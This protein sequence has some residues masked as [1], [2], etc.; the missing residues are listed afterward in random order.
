MKCNAQAIDNITESYALS[1]LHDALK[2]IR[3][4]TPKKSF[5]LKKAASSDIRIGYLNKRPVK[6]LVVTLRSSGCGWIKN[7]F[8]CTMCGHYAGTTKGEAI[9]RDYFLT[10]FT[11]EIKKYDFSDIPILCLYNAG[12]VLNS[13]EL[14]EAA[15]TGICKEISKISGIKKVVFETRSEYVTKDA[16]F[17]IKRNLR[18]TDVDIALGIESSS[19]KIRELC[20]NKGLDM[21]DFKRAIALIKEHFNLRLYLMIKPIFLTESEGIS[22]AVRSFFDIL[23]FSPD[24][25]H[26]EPATIQ[27]H[28]LSY[29][30]HKSNLYRAP[31]LWSIIEVLKRIGPDRMVYISPFA[32]TPSPVIVPYNCEKCTEKITRLLLDDY[33]RNFDGSVFDGLTCE[34]RAEY[35][36]ELEKIDPRSLE[37]RVLDYL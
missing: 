6:R 27:E 16:L 12:S 24:E 26:F 9:P 18:Q 35:E 22:D 1:R 29:E 33:N 36:K 13:D 34:C 11:S 30:M 4:K 21:P 23:D 14:N 25:V 15:L 17:N 5:D 7:S 31:W 3:E 28:T 8:G 20:L 32:H 19:E 37:E 10:Q 2:S